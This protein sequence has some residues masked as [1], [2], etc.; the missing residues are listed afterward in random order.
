MTTPA[1]IHPS[2]FVSEDCKIGEDS[3]IWHFCHVMG[4]AEIGDNCSLGQ[5]CFV[6]PNVTIAE[7]CRLQNNI[8]VYEGVVLEEGVFCGPSCVFTNDITPR[9]PSFYEGE[10]Y[11]PVKT[12]VKRGASIGANATIICGITLG[13]FC[14]IGAGATVTSDVVPHALM[15]GAPARQKGWVSQSGAILREDMTCTHTGQ[16]Y[17]EREGRLYLVQ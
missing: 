11:I 8:S 5:N 17:E 4:N 16:K 9:T 6:A 7:G 2:A 1:Y 12:L 3:K 13:E 10:P 15:L 14:M